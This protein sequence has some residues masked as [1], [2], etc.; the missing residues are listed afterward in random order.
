MHDICAII[1]FNTP[2]VA[3][4]VTPFTLMMMIRCNFDGFVYNLP[5]QDKCYED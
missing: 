5:N 3:L 2:S 4:S 1:F